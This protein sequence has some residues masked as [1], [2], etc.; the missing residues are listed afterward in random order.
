MRNWSD[1]ISGSYKRHQDLVNISLLIILSVIVFYNSLG[2]YFFEVDD[3]SL[4]IHSK[5]NIVQAFTSDTYGSSSGGN[6]RPFEV[7]LQSFDSYLF[8]DGN[9][10]A[11][12][13]T[14]LIIHIFN[15]ILVYIFCSYLSKKK[16][17][18]LIAG[19][20]FSVFIIHSYPMSPVL[21]ITGRTELTLT[22]FYLVAIILFIRSKSS[23]SL[24]IYIISVI[25][26]FCALLCKEMAATL[27]LIILLYLKLFSDEKEGQDI[28]SLKHLSLFLKTLLLSG[29]FLIALGILL[30][31]DFVARHFSADGMLKEGTINRIHYL[32]RTAVLG[33]GFV[34]ASVIFILLLSKYSTRISKLLSYYRYSI[35]YF[36]VLLFFL[37]LRFAVIGQFGGQYNTSQRNI[38][39]NF[40]MDAFARDI[41][42]LAGLVWPLNKEYNIDVFGLQIEH[43]FIFYAVAIIILL[44][45]LLILV[46][47]IVTHSKK[48]TFSYLWFFITLL[49]VHN[50]LITSWQFQPRYFYLPSVGLFIFISILLYKLTQSSYISKRFSKFIVSAFI[51][52]VVVICSLLIVKNVDRIKKDG[53]I[54]RNFVSDMKKYKSNI[55]DSTGLYFITFPYTSVSSPCCVYIYAY[56]DEVLNFIYNRKNYG[57]EYNYNILSYVKGGDADISNIDWLDKKNFLYESNGSAQYYFIPTKF[58]SFEEKIKNIY[59]VFPHAPLQLLPLTGE[60]VDGSIHYKKKNPAVIEV[61]NSNK[62]GDRLQLSFKLGDPEVKKENDILFFFYEKGHFK[63]VKEFQ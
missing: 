44:I 46:R 9:A 63:M 28:F 30:G 45:L 11:K 24:V 20:L 25:S 3:F 2:N 31:P 8:G 55:T 19:L 52:L 34:V 13:I 49:P 4:L 23:A 22:F 29:I 1:G 47:F 54:M 38:T 56:M 43:N 57:K 26:F 51:T 36:F 32:Q 14:S 39:L 21:W 62:K 58:S 59:G 48:L 15:V 10:Q 53:Q 16:L 27:P 17:I 33:G 60:A 50:L 18:G 41:F 40:G 61:L 7:L 42:S 37:I 35:P 5:R 6:Y 12:H